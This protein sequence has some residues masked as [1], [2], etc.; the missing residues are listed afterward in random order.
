MP[1]AFLK[2]RMISFNPFFVTSGMQGRKNYSEKLFVSFQLSDRVP[3]ENFYRRLR[4]TLDLQF[5]YKDTRELY[6]KT[7]NPSIDPVVFFKLMLTGYLENITSDRRL[8]EHCS[9]RMDV[10]YFIGYDIDEPL[11]WHST[12][13]RTRQLYPA[14]LF[15]S[16]FDKVFTMC[17]ENG[18]VAG[19]THAIDSAPIKANASIENLELKVPAQS[20][21]AHFTG[22]DHYNPDMRANYQDDNT[23]MT[24]SPSQL[25]RLAKYQDNLNADR[26]NR[27]KASNEK[28]QLLSNKTHYNPHDPD[29]RISIKPGKARKL[30][31][32]CSMSVDVAKGVISHIQADFADGRDSQYLPRIASVLKDRLKRNCLSLTDL[33]ADTGYSNGY[34]YQFLEKRKIAGW[35]PVFGKFKPLV[36][37]FDYNKETDSYPCPNRKGLPFRSLEY[38]TDGKP[39]KAYWTTRSDCVSCP[40]NRNVFQR[41]VLREL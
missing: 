28:A 41:L 33:M 4:E 8:M 23:V 15:E 26:P 38:S 12:V 14:T 40:L 37:G 36:D 27:P 35:I 19:H 1:A 10:L 5:L 18:M 29:A 20:I 34:N 13:S 11:P 9:M 22:V 39:L 17:V 31:Y 24:A 25:K 7:G 6:G 16:L 3:K 30:N 2:S 32:H 21:T